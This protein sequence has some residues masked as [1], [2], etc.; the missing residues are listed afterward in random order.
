MDARDETLAAI[1]PTGGAVET[2]PGRAFTQ[3]GREGKRRLDNELLSLA[4]HELRTPLAVIRGHGELLRAR[5]CEEAPRVCA[6]QILAAAEKLGSA[7]DLL[8][9]LLALDTPAAAPARALLNLDAV[10]ADATARVPALASTHAPVGG[11]PRSACG[12]AGQLATAVAALLAA[13]LAGAAI[14]SL[15][16]DLVEQDG[17]AGISVTAA[18]GW[19]RSGQFQLAAFIGRRVMKGNHGSLH[20]SHAAG[21]STV[22]LLLPADTGQ[23][24]RRVLIVDDDDSV[25]SLRRAT[26]P[27]EEGFE[28]VEARDGAG[29][30]EAVKAAAPD[31][32]L[33]DWSMP[34]LSGADVL[35]QLRSTG[36]RAHVVVLTAEIEPAYRL[37]A[38]AL[39]AEAFL[40]KPFSPIELLDLIE[41]LL[42]RPA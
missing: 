29:A 19:T 17:L 32:I 6:D 14:E 38:Q 28:I 10:L 2:P 42:E 23:P 26:L 5:A 9:A 18:D 40:T 16:V 11:E 3:P 30:L 36:S 22:K 7:V 37:R 12:D 34:G 41:R 8:L 20:L 21:S 35:T 25:R 31:L 4:G 27:E 24:G 33:L 1:P 39:G 13:A 15:T